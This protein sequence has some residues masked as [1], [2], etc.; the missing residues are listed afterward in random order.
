[1]DSLCR[2]ARERGIALIFSTHDRQHA[3]DYADEILMLKE[4]KLHAVA[5]SSL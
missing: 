4:G 3:A 1:M 2:E 5:E